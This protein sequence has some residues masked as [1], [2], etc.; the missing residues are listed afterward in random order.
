MKGKEAEYVVPLGEVFKQPRPKRARKAIV[1]IRRFVK[2]HTRSE[3]VVIDNEVNEKVWE[4]AKNIPRRVSVV[5]VDHANKINVYLKDGKRLAEDKKKWEQEEK[6]KKK[7]K[8]DKAK[9]RGKAEEKEKGKEDE[10]DAEMNR[11]KEQKKKD[12]KEKELA[13]EKSA[14]KRKTN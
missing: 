13:A 12:K 14:M 7:K 3:N 5:L 9:D 1:A 8:G 10:K 11:E 4:N 2:K 6:D